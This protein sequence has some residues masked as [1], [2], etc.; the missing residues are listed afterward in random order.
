[1]CTAFGRAVLG[2]NSLVLCARCADI[3]PT[4]SPLL[5]MEYV[6]KPPAGPPY[7]MRSVAN[8]LGRLSSR[9]ERPAERLLQI[10][11]AIPFAFFA[12]PHA[13]LLAA[14]CQQIASLLA[15]SLLFAARCKRRQLTWPDNAG[16]PSL[17]F[18]TRCYAPF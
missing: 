6:V 9:V 11:S 8:L 3:D 18:A 2:N 14:Q 15:V 5:N 12:C 13:C 10:R 7:C 1:M 17:R 16:E 4:I